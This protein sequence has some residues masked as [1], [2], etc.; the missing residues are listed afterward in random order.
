MILAGEADRAGRVILVG[1]KPHARLSAMA[2]PDRV[3]REQ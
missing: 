2:A 3:V 1:C